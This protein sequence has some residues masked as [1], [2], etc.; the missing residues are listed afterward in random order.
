MDRLEFL[1][2]LGVLT[3]GASLMGSGVSAMAAEAE[4]IP[5]IAADKKIKTKMPVMDAGLSKPVTVMI[6]GAGG[7]GRTYARYA[8]KFPQSMKVVGVADLNPNR[9]KAMAKKH[10]IPAEN[11]FG[12]FNDALSKAKLAD[13]VVI[14]TPDNLHYEPCMK[15]LELGYDVLLEK[16]VAPTERECRAILKQAHKYNRIV[17]VCHVLR[18][19]PYFVALKQVLESGAI[20]DIVNIQHFEPIRYAHMAHSYV[21][22][23]WPLSTKTTPIILAKSCHDLD[24]LRWL[25]DK[26]CET[27]AAEGSLHLFRP[28]N[29]PKGAPERCTDG[30]PHEA[31]CPYSAIDIYERRKQHLGAFDLPRKD[32]ALIREKLKTTNYGRCVFR[33]END[34]CDHYVAIM[35]FQDGV[36]ASFSMDAFTPWGGRRTR[37][38]GTKGFIEGDMTTFTFYDFRTSHKSVW[39]QKVS[40][41]PE[42]KGSG[43]GGGDHLL[44]RDFLRAVSAQDEKLLSS[45]IDVSIESHVMGFMAEKSRKSNKKMKI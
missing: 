21:R 18:Y 25:I 4:D 36:T 12:H 38:M 10:N 8:E 9:R 27:I 29:A 26:P 20:G 42:Y 37:I 13:A 41:I 1:K 31:E 7:R 43:H 32:P 24:I 23:N 22:G 45:T 14:A 33:C 16:P 17:A 3:V 39:D 11:Q 28:E 34:Q 30:C 15:A 2:R 40:E 35:K 6:I 19:A 5:E 44:V